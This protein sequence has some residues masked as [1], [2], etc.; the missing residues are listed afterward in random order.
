MINTQY[1]DELDYQFI[2]RVQKEV[3]QSCAL[4]F[5]LPAERIP[6]YIL[7]AAGWFYENVDMACEERMYVIKNSL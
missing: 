5:A 6:E 7:Q 3:T 1:E 2:L 4:P